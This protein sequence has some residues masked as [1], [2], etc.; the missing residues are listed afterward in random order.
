MP[1][2]VASLALFLLLGAAAWAQDSVP[3][4]PA[5]QALS[6]QSVEPQAQQA[7]PTQA[8]G[9]GAPKP[10][11]NNEVS[12]SKDTKIDL[13]P[14][15]DDATHPG[16]AAAADVNEFH[17][18]DPHKADKDVEVGD[19]YFKK[20]NYRAALSRYRSALRW[21]PNDAIATFRLAQ[22]LEKTGDLEE[23]R[24]QYAAYLKILPYGP[25]A[26]EA[27]KALDRLLLQSQSGGSAEKHR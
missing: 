15:P 24:A 13:S 20:K 11:G 10:T 6:G 21:K 18:Y 14:P 1:R 2:F 19:F 26:K 16:S 3:P 17:A 4:P 23:A 8:P 9:P 27:Q 25:N 5:P 22:A 7:P 12:S